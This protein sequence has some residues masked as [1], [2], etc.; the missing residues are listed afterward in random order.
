MRNLEKEELEKITNLSELDCSGNMLITNL[1]P[2]TQIENLKKIN[3]SNTSITNLDVLANKRLLEVL[4]ISYTSI[5]SLEPLEKLENIKLI[6][7]Y[8]TDISQIEIDRFKEIKP[9]CEV[10][11]NQSNKLIDFEIVDNLP[12]EVRKKVKKG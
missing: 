4:D 1:H 2:I 8:H 12:K 7:C 9:N 5:L 11:K 6:K 10:L 3:C